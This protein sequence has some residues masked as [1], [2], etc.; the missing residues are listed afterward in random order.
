MDVPGGPVTVTSVVLGTAEAPVLTRAA[1]WAPPWWRFGHNDSYALRTAEGVVLIDP[2]AVADGEV[3]FWRE[4]GERPVAQV[5]TTD[6]HERGA[7]AL[8]E[9]LGVPVWAPAAG[10]PDRGGELEGEPDH[11]YD[12][13]T[14]LPGGLRALRLLGAGGPPGLKADHVL[15]WRAPSGETVLFTGDVLNGGSE[16]RHPAFAELDRRAH[17]LYAGVSREHVQRVGPEALRRALQPL[18]REPVDLICGGHGL[19]V[20]RH[21]RSALERLLSLDWAALIAAGRDVG[22]V[23]EQAVR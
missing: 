8:R 12:E 9:R 19:P 15:V 3:P 21:A 17:G 7:P 11:T 20:R 18:L 6:Q 16:P 5:L 1:H 2:E 14:A 13:G 23:D 10:L 22:V 4:L